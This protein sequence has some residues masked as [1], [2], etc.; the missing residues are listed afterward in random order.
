MN[1][2]GSA[3]KYVEHMIRNTVGVK[4]LLLD[5]E[6][7]NFISVAATKTELYSNEV[8]I[9]EELSS[10]LQKPIDPQV[11]S[12]SCV[13]I[14]RPT[15]SNVDMLCQELRSPHFSKYALYF[16]NTVPDYLF[17]QIATADTNMIIDSFQEVFLDFSALGT[18][19]FSSNMP[20]ISDFRLNPSGKS[21]IS[22]KIS[23]S[24]FAAICCLRAIP[25]VRYDGNSESC[26]II[27]NILQ[28]M[29]NN[30]NSLFNSS[31]DDKVNV[32][33]L[34]RRNDPVTPLLHYFYYLPIL[35]DLFYIDNNVISLNKKD[36]L[37]IDERCDPE[38][39]KINTMYLEEAGNAI[40]QRFDTF[41]SVQKQIKDQNVVSMNEK[42]LH[43]LQSSSAITYSKT[44][45]ELYQAMHRKV[46]SDNLL[47]ITG[48]EQIMAT[49]ND[50][51]E[52]CEQFCNLISG[53]C[54]NF[55][56]L[57][58][59]LIYCLH[60]EKSGDELIGRV[61][62]ALEQKSGFS[63]DELKYAQTLIRIAGQDKR[64]FDIFSN[65]SLIA[66]F[67]GG[68][69][70]STAKS[71]FEMYKI[72][73]E[74]LLKDVKEKRLDQNRYPFADSKMQNSHSYKTI[75][76]IVGGAT[77]AEHCAITRMTE[78]KAEGRPGFQFVL[79]GT[80]IHNA[81]TFIRYEVAP[82]THI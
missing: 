57:R 54:S 28:S 49:V 15:N 74:D 36:Q 32:L 53:K 66:K 29:I 82:F 35:H 24:L 10:R 6:T 43:V 25:I 41:K 16:T 3:F 68:L 11:Q 80:T 27:A 70:S 51:Q 55:N 42:A 20:D 45:M 12:I 47:D 8:A 71:Q 69:K 33:I 44:H 7:L 34:D 59:A 1:I 79:G 81:E 62:N 48:L 22:T 4:A 67:K 37:I 46:V 73:L 63:Q 38:T 77:Y 17:H 26:K 75:V 50:S 39:E 61:M 64:T 30:N 72:P 78:P 14:L 18:R 58:L 56:A 65:R 52:Q 31:K 76:Y 21:G 40:N 60:Y 19:L 9:I 5:K 23:E 2:Q 13:C